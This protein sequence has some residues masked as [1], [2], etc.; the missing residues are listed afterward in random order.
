MGKLSF[1][2]N[3]GWLNNFGDRICCNSENSWRQAWDPWYKHYLQVTGITGSYIYYFTSLE[4]N[5][6]AKSLEISGKV[7]KPFLK[8][9]EKL[10][11]LG[12]YWQ[13][14]HKTM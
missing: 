7:E 2:L 12:N 1:S 4:A 6:I 14:T 3:T 5:E 13:K 10:E 9:V 11:V 8:S